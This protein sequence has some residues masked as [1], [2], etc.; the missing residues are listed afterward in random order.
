M[1][2]VLQTQEVVE[3]LLSVNP[4]LQ[5]SSFVVESLLVGDPNVEIGQ[6]VVEILLDPGQ[7][8]MDGSQLVLEVLTSTTY[9]AT[10]SVERGIFAGKNPSMEKSTGLIYPEQINRIIRSCPKF[11]DS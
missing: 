5:S 4:G 8:N 3:A 6:V 9:F 7:I 2:A 1:T 11:N 10:D